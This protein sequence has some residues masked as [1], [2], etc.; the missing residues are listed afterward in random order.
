MVVLRVDAENGL[1]EG[2]F[3][4]GGVESGD[5]ESTVVPDLVGLEVG[6]GEVVGERE[7]GFER[8]LEV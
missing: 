5:E 7:F 1:D 4:F 3:G 8:E 6:F 2:K